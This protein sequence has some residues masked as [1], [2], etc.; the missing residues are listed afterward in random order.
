MSLQNLESL[1]E[2]CLQVQ[3]RLLRGR[4]KHPERLC[5]VVGL[6]ELR[7]VI[8]VSGQRCTYKR[9]GFVPG[10]PG[11]RLALEQRFVW[12]LPLVEP[13]QGSRDLKVR[14]FEMPIAA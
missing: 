11:G 13:D 1:V 6:L 9:H 7:A 5:Y 10:M 2:V 3:Q 14:P 8:D 12:V 4:R